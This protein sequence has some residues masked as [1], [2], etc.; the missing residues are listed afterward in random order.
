LSSGPFAFAAALM[1]REIVLLLFSERVDAVSPA[2][3]TW[4]LTATVTATG[5]EIGVQS[6]KNGQTLQP[7]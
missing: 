7:W 5:T 4:K 3:S 6:G 1:S 2:I